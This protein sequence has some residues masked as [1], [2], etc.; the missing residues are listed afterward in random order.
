MATKVLVTT[1]QTH[2]YVTTVQD[3]IWTATG[4]PIVRQN[5]AQDILAAAAVTVLV[6]GA[7]A[8]AI[9]DGV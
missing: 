4:A 3:S 7:R 2:A 9:L 8:V 6:L 1:T 5:Y